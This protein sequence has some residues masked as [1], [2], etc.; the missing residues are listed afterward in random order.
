MLD[1]E[2]NTVKIATLIDIDHQKSDD[3]I[4]TDFTS[5]EFGFPQVEQVIWGE[6]NRKPVAQEIWELE[7]AKAAKLA[8]DAAQSENHDFR[9]RI[10]DL[11]SGNYFLV[12]TGACVS[13]FP[14]KNRPGAVLDE[15]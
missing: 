2:E 9:P 12:D 7:V 13:V 3:K 10:K 1:H 15:G 6:F 14:L 11:N 8:V 4:Y 5:N